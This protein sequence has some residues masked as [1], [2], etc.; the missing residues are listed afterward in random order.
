M[1][2][3]SYLDSWYW[4][5]RYIIQ[6]IYRNNHLSDLDEFEC[7]SGLI[8]IILPR[9]E[10]FVKLNKHG[11]PIFDNELS[12][13]ERAKK[14]DDILS[15]IQFSFEFFYQDSF[16][17]RKAKRLQAKIKRKY[18]DWE[19][20]TKENETYFFMVHDKDQKLGTIKFSKEELTDENIEQLKQEKCERMGLNQEPFYYDVELYNKISKEAVEGI[21]LFGEYFLNLWD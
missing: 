3:K 16:I 1:R 19:A 10:A 14:W 18:G 21:K 20:K 12:D 6:K 4:K 9:I 2:I 7:Y 13:I 17:D 5:C 11:T 8:K 15:K